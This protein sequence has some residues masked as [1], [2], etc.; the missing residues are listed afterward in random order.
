MPR[1]RTRRCYPR[2]SVTL[3]APLAIGHDPPVPDDEDYARLGWLLD[4]PD[5]WTD[6]DLD[7]ARFM[8]AN[9]KDTLAGLH[10]K[11][12]S[13]RESAQELIDRFEAALRAHL[14]LGA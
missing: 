7:A 1:T 4:H 5:Q 2:T 13:G 9:Q 11:D 10:P 12:A 3:A 8:L 14:A 6:A